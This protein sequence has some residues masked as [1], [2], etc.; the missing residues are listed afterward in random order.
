MAQGIGY[1]RKGE[2]IKEIKLGTKGRILT[3]DEKP[4]GTQT[5]VFPKQQRHTFEE[6]RG[7]PPWNGRQHKYCWKV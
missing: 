6:H 5:K 1:L 2:Y 3:V 7:A 4:Q